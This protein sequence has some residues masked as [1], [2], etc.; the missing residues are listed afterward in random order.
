MCSCV[1][2]LDCPSSIYS[3]FLIPNAA[4]SPSLSL[5]HHFLSHLLNFKQTGLFLQKAICHLPYGPPFYWFYKS[6]V[7][8]HLR[9]FHYFS[10]YKAIAVHYFFVFFILSKFHQSDLFSLYYFIFKN[11]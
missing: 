2:F 7:F 1:P 10:G 4:S 8:N 9:P 11:N 3:I 5:S 6:M